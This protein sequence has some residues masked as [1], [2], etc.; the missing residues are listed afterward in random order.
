MAPSSFWSSNSSLF[1]FS[2][3][4]DSSFE[5]A[6]LC[7]DSLLSSFN[8]L[9]SSPFSWSK[10]AF[11]SFS[12]KPDSS[13]ELTTVC[14]DS[15]LSSFN[16]STS[17]LFSWSKSTFISFPFK[18]DSSFE[19]TKVCGSFISSFSSLTS[20]PFSWS[21]STFLSFA[22]TTDLSFSLATF[23]NDS[24]K[25]ASISTTTVLFVL[26]SNSLPFSLSFKLDSSLELATIDGVFATGCC[27][28]ALP[29]R[30]SVAS[31]FSVSGNAN[32]SLSTGIASLL[33]CPLANPSDSL[34]ILLL[35]SSLSVFI[36]VNSRLSFTTIWFSPATADS[37]S[38][39]PSGFDLGPSP[40]SSITGSLSLISGVSSFSLVKPFL[41][42]RRCS[43]SSSDNSAFAWVDNS[44]P[45]ESL[46]LSWSSLRWSSS[47]L[48]LFWSL[49]LLLASSLLWTVPTEG[50][51]LTKVTCGANVTSGL[52]LF[53]FATSAITV[54]AVREFSLTDLK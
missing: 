51:L 7:C 28:S 23:L 15:L 30:L 43:K 50:G 12:F 6:T 52:T 34:D 14:D 31:T 10:S 32:W 49:M 38:F 22:F 46:W 40:A 5:L 9:T 44:S 16:S 3:K 24:V 26:G 17:S 29:F 41:F 18:S 13:F 33:S 53:S 21:K 48:S 4:T 20:A 27:W 54:C 45:I 47:M 36:T 25:S 8:S 11:P 37:N 39:P 19:F 42:T 1:S 35:S 2:V